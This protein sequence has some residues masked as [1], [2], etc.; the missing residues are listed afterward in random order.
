[1]KYTLQSGVDRPIS[2]KFTDNLR[3]VLPL[4]FIFLLVVALGITQRGRGGNSRKPLTL[5]I[6]TVKTPDPNQNGGSSN[7]GGNTNSPSSSSSAASL[8]TSS[9][10]PVASGAV[11]PSDSSALTASTVPTTTTPPQTSTPP[12]PL[13]FPCFDLSTGLNVTCTYQACTP[14]VALIGSQKAYLTVTDT[15]A[16]VN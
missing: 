12:A 6:Y 11:A 7:G 8:N 4:L 9:L 13:T 16:I 1:M 5:G 2:Q 3:F 14:P 10:S 15:C